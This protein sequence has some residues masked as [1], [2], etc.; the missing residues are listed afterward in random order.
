MTEL[1]RQHWGQILDKMADASRDRVEVATIPFPTLV[2]DVLQLPLPT[3]MFGRMKLRI[4][5]ARVTSIPFVA[6]PPTLL[7]EKAHAKPRPDIKPK[8][9]ENHRA[10]LP[11][12]MPIRDRLRSLLQPPIDILLGDNQVWL[13]FEPFPYQYEGIQFLFGRWSAM[14]GDEM[15]LGKTM[16]TILAMR[17]LLRAG[18]I[19]TAILV[20]PKPLVTNWLRE[21][22]AWADEIPILR[23]EGNNF[24][25]RNLWLHDRSP[26]K[27]TNY[28]SISRDE[29]L[30]K[31]GHVNFDLCV[32]DEAQRIKNRD[33]KTARVIHKIRRNRSWALTGT[34][35]ENRATDLMSLL[36]FA[37]NGRA[38]LEDRPDVLRKEVSEVL[39]RRTKEMV[40][41]DMPPRII[42]DAYIDLSPNQRERYDAAEKEGVCKLNDMEDA[43]T[44]EH[45]FELIRWLKQICNFDPI[46]GES[47][48]AEQLKSDME[49]IAE[50]GKK[51]IL[52]SQWVTTITK[53][54]EELKDFNPL[55]Y[56]GGI[57]QKHRDPVLQEFK[58]S[59]DRPLLM[60]SYA[61]GAVGL[62]LQFTNYVFLYDRWWNP[63]IEDQ[64][65]NRA[66]RI[67][68]K[69]S[70]FVSRFI[71]PGTI[72][73]RIAG[74]LEQKRDLFA[75]LI[76]DVDNASSGLTREEVFG[77]FDLRIHPKL[78]A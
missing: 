50:S 10:K 70:V 53:L 59:K 40:M 21:F 25:R 15:G 74:V 35:V 5:P 77:L 18:M 57:P 20:C 30:F 60:L 69:D 7:E 61:T 48:K 27:I 71:S 43:V 36:E 33:S 37:N 75:S 2:A 14:L 39:L 42:R 38:P 41:S 64:A 62:N 45:V 52:F 46:T 4:T 28:E 31:E 51:A 47:A 23:V 16:Q 72:E 1:F 73:E 49:E 54:S 11:D 17:L 13:P 22:K 32:I 3:P 58:A 76:G 24:T 12:E 68:Q 8:R 78:A 65:I 63:A 34:P 9:A 55:V 44:I 19:R 67:G 6:P 66:H 56:H 29:D 26:V